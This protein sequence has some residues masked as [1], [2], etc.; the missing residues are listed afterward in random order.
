MRFRRIP[1]LHALNPWA[2]ALEARRAS[3]RELLDLTIANPTHAGLAADA[4][5]LAALSDPRGATYEPDPRGLRSAR[6]AVAAT[7]TSRGGAVSPA[8]LVL[9]AGTSEAYAHLFRMLADPGECLLV[10][11]PGYPM[12]DPI[13]ALEGVRLEPYRMAWD[14][15]WHLD[16]GDLDRALEHDP[17]AVIVVQPAV[18]AGSCL[19]AAE[20]NAI[21]RRCAE[22]EI[23]VISDEVFADFPWPPATA[24]VP[25]FG[26][27]AEALT[28]V[29]GGLSKSCGLPQL[30]LSWIAV[31]GPEPARR[32]ALAG[33]EWISDL[34]LT[35]GT[36]VQ[37]A[38]PALLP[39]RASFQ[40][41]T[42]ERLAVN[43]ERLERLAQRRPEVRR[44]G[45][46]AG[47]SAALRLPARKTGER[48]ALELLERG[49]AVH[50]GEFYDLE[51]GAHL[52]V[53]LLTPPAEFDRGLERLEELAGA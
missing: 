20:R 38:L 39:V 10:P 53:S 7:L 33:L 14:G 25:G 32:E 2:V 28:F 3:G 19:D 9:T 1:E 15:A 46:E 45:G 52:V 26:G 30:K 23:A 41:R 35:V 29:L 51:G 27:T 43:L 8:D 34:F 6:E 12:F 50:P 11:A 22:R 31:S 5:L 44:L 21:V 49:V 37:V 42:R 40:R 18:P 48:W 36:P 17:R 24:P 13:A 47:W 16:L 4:G